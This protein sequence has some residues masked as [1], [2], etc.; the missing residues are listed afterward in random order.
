MTHDSVRRTSIAVFAAALVAAAAPLSAQ[1]AASRADPTS[2]AWD[3]AHALLAAGSIPTSEVI[4]VARGIVCRSDLA[5][6][7]G[8]IEFELG[9]AR[10]TYAGIAFRIGS[11][12]DYELLVFRPGSN[13]RWLAAQ[14]Y[15]VHQGAA[16]WQLYPGEGY[17]ADIPAAAAYTPDGWLPVRI[18]IAGPRADVSVAGASAPVLRVKGLVRDPVIGATGVW[19]QGGKDTSASNASVRAFRVTASNVLRL[20][21]LPEAAV[22]PGHVMRWRI[23]PRF[24]A[25]DSIR[26]AD[27]LSPAAESAT[28]G[29]SVITA[30]RTGLVDFTT[31]IGN[32]AGAQTTEAFNGAGWG[33]A[34][35]RVTIHAAAR[36]VRRLGLTYSDAVGV[37]LNGALVYEGDNRLGARNR[38]QLGS[39]GSEAERVALHLRPGDNEVV[40]AVADRAFGWGFSATLDATDGLRIVP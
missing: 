9:P 7:N 11:P 16:A 12:L 19:T 4:A 18:V 8:T 21:P 32:P 10:D 2:S 15:P 28:R 6:R 25:P 40:I 23:S 17:E 22:S 13:G 30:S 36:E 3:T 29:G 38:Y 33:L 35:A 37:Y 1:C 39:I 31:L 20:D 24:D 34:Y 26:F 14:Y 5:M 27:A